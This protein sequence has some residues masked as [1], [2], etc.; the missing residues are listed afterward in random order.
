[1]GTAFTPTKPI[2]DWPEIAAAPFLLIGLALA[3]FSK[4]NLIL[5]TVCF[6]VGLLFG[7]AWYV[8]KTRE[9]V[10]IFLAIM[11]FFLGFILGSLY[12]NLRITVFVLLL[13]ALAGYWIQEK[14]IIEHV[15]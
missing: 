1:M 4:N 6:L 3:I 9:K 13:G 5:Y 15:F 10:P 12:A 14:N 7:R 2:L 11:T 8:N